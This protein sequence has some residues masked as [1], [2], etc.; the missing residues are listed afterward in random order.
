MNDNLYISY[1]YSIKYNLVSNKLWWKWKSISFINRWMVKQLMY[2]GFLL[3]VHVLEFILSRSLKLSLWTHS[4]TWI[5]VYDNGMAK[6]ISLIFWHFFYF[7]FIKQT[8]HTFS[9]KTFSPYCN[10]GSPSKCMHTPWYWRFFVFT[11]RHC[12]AFL[13]KNVFVLTFLITMTKSYLYF[14]LWSIICICIYL[15]IRNNKYKTLYTCTPKSR[16]ACIRVSINNT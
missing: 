11:Y 9:I 6:H 4:I 13:A 7:R 16:V 2:C 10:C 1:S 15:G 3:L 12:W 5:L 8:N 14:S